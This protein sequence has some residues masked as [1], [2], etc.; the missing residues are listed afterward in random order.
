M[1]DYQL[2]PKHMV[3]HIPLEEYPTLGNNNKNKYS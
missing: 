1:I 3:H 2:I